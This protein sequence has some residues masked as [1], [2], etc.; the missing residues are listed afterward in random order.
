[1]A[2][3]KNSVSI[4]SSPRVVSVD[5]EDSETTG[6]HSATTTG[7]D[8]ATTGTDSVTT[9]GTGSETTEVVEVEADLV[10]FFPEVFF[11]LVVTLVALALEAV[12]ADFGAGILW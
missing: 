10:S 4:L 11:C 2:R 7:T 12:E 1:M 6:A 3:L 5:S 8:S 9:T